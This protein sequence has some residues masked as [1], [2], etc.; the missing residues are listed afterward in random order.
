MDEKE[1]KL[2]TFGDS[3]LFDTGIAGQE[4]PNLDPDAINL[5]INSPVN[6]PINSPVN[7]AVNLPINSTLNLPMTKKKIC[8]NE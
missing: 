8:L 4:L 1:A 6:L 2:L 5:P 3:D 7:S